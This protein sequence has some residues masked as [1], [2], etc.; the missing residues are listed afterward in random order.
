MSEEFGASRLPVREALGI[1][2][3]D[4]LVRLAAVNYTDD[5]I[6]RWA[7]MAATIEAADD[8]EQYLKLDRSFYLES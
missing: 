6:T 5:D 1:L 8:V 3:S 2:E 7:E 4:V